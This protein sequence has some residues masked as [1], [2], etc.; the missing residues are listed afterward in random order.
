MNDRMLQKWMEQE[1]RRIMVRIPKDLGNEDEVRIFREAV[2]KF[3]TDTGISQGNLAAEIGV[4]TTTLSLFLA[5]KYSGKVE[6]VVR[7]LA[8][9][10]NRSCRRQ[11]RSKE[12]DYVNTTVAQR[13]LQAIKVTEQFTTNSEGRIC[14]IAGDSGGGK[15]KC[16]E[17]YAA[18]NPLAVYIK[19]CDKMSTVALMSRIAKALKLDSDGGLKRLVDDLT[20]HLK[21]REMTII[22]DEAAGLDVGRLNLLRQVISESGCTLV[23]AG[24]A[25]L[26]KTIYGSSATR[27]NE[28]LDQFRSRMLTVVNLDELA[29]QAPGDGGVFTVDDVRKLYS[30]GLKLSGDAEGLLLSIARSPQSG[31]LRTCSVIVGSINT[32]RQARD[33]RISEITADLILSTIRQLGLCVLPYLPLEPM[34]DAIEQRKVKTA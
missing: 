11:R 28:S 33:G 29:S 16:L 3:M 23:L 2:K 19:L 5:G 1:A 26:L 18:T 12:P 21:T 13:I 30:S 17:Q 25:H 27:G 15:T 6:S 9:Y 24:N 22:C 14:V 31:R 20:E 7:G 34:A 10:I 8:E 4:S 32:S